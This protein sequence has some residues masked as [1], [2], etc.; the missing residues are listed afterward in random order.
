[1]T[2][3]QELMKNSP[4]ITSVIGM[5]LN[6]LEVNDLRL[7]KIC[8]NDKSILALTYDRENDVTVPIQIRYE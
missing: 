4:K 1:M 6:C 8:H 5:V 3:W 7:E 2:N